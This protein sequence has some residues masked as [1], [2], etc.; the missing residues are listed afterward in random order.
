MK[1]GLAHIE[2]RRS[3]GQERLPAFEFR[4]VQLHRQGR[5]V[6]RFKKAPQKEEKKPEEKSEGTD[7]STE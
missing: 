5:I 1:P 4:I 3:L 6:R 7:T 2:M